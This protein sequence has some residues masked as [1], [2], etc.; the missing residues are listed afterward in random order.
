MDTS[1]IPLVSADA[2]V[3]EPRT[4][5]WDGLPASMRE[6]APARIKP[7]ESGAW[8]LHRHSE[9]DMT[10]R[11]KDL[12]EEHARNEQNDINYRLGIMHEDGIAAECV[13]PTIG[14]YVWDM[15]DAALGDAC[16]QIYNDWIYDSLEAKS[17]R[18]RCAGLIPT[19]DIDMAVREARRIADMGLGSIMLPL[20]GVPWEYNSPNW[21]PLWEAVEETSLPIVMHQGSGHDMLF[22]RGPGATVANLLATQ[23]MA[24]RTVGLLAASGTLER[25]P[26]LH[27]VFVETNA[28]WISWAMDTLD[29]YYDAFTAIPGWVR[30]ELKEKPSSYVARQIHGTFQWDPTG[31]RN[32]ARTG[33]EPL[34]WGSDYPHSEGTYPHS[35]KVVQEL[36]DQFTQEDATAILGGTATR[37]FHFDPAVVSTPV[38]APTVSG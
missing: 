13:F 38:P 36:F 30:P 10:Q 17:P 20:K 12:A 15:D 18:H 32:L 5:W 23:S 14:L 25:H 24:P 35:R 16:C 2:H 11:Q 31:L 1:K 3:N 4:L 7:S 19:W 34:L 29:Y 28:A 21:E 27:F 37:L 6:R 8:S 26:G 9:T 33:V 22:Y